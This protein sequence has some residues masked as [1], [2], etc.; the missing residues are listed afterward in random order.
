[1]LPNLFQFIIYRTFLTPVDQNFDSNLPRQ[2]NF[3]VNQWWLQSSYLRMSQF[4]YSFL[5]R[6]MIVR[7]LPWNGT[8]GSKAKAKAKAINYIW[9]KEFE[10]KGGPSLS[11][12]GFNL[13]TWHNF[14]GEGSH[15][16]ES[17]LLTLQFAWIEISFPQFEFL[18]NA[19]WLNC[20]CS[21]CICSTRI[22]FNHFCLNHSC[23]K[24]RNTYVTYP[25]L[26]MPEL[27]SSYSSWRS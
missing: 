17:H 10:R 12:E 22:C 11:P 19:L 18:N 26:S 15:L 7:L 25:S 21:N 16:L 6:K 14:E 24:M 3:F 1:M 4:Y 2:F 5:P 20:I 27:T 13:S 9:P 8:V 23:L